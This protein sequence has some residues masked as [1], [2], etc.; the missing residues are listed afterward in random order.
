MMMNNRREINVDMNDPQSIASA[1][2]KADRLY[3]ES[4]ML[5]DTV[6]TSA[7]TY[8]LVFEKIPE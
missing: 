4:Y 2:R 7:S 8:K 1:E 3:S 6:G 5:V